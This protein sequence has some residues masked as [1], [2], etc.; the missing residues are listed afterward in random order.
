M[1]RIVLT[2][3]EDNV[4]WVTSDE[5]AIGIENVFEK[6]TTDTNKQMMI[7]LAAFLGYEPSDILNFD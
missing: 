2:K 1:E 4:I 5:D 7:A 6:N 3:C